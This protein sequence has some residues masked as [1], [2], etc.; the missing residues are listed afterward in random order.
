MEQK[1]FTIITD[2]G[3]EKEASSYRLKKPIELTHIVIGDGNGDFYRPV[4]EMTELKREVYKTKL[5]RVY[6]KNKHQLIVESSIPD[7]A[8]DFYVREVGILDS[9]GD[10]FAIGNYPETYKPKLR[11]GCAKDLYL[12]IIIGF[13]SAPNVNLSVNSNI[14]FVTVK[15][16][17]HFANDDLSNVDNDNLLS[18]LPMDS[19]AKTDL[20]NISQDILMEK[21]PTQTFGCPVGSAFAYMGQLIP[22]GYLLLDGSTVGDEDSGAKYAG[23]DYKELYHLF[24]QDGWEA[25]EVLKLPDCRGRGIIGSGHGDGLTA[26]TFGEI[27]GEELH[28]L[29]VAEMPAHGHIT[30]DGYTPPT[31]G[32]NSINAND[33]SAGGHG[34]FPINRVY[35]ESSH[36]GGNQP[37]NNMPPYIA[38]NWIIKY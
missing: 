22:E 36:T 19:L 20:S 3:L 30:L 17:E 15:D 16:I 10:L 4:P 34:A 14:S 24:S 33:A 5:S 31:S 37:H 9:D 13:S 1:Y 12:R 35:K 23:A 7:N 38:M 2:K 8:G 26:R 28:Q 18:K 32:I 6:N 25:S 21:L 11:G 27:G 29:T